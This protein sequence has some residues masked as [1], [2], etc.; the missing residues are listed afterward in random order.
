MHYASSLTWPR[1]MPTS[2]RHYSERIDLKRLCRGSGR[3]SSST[4]RTWISGG[5]LGDLLAGL[6]EP[7]EAIACLERARAL[8]ER[9]VRASIFRSAGL[10]EQDGRMSEAEEH[11]RTALR[12]Q[13][14]WPRSMFTSVDSMRF[15]GSLDDGR[16]RFPQVHRD[17]ARV[18]TRACPAGD[19]AAVDC[20]QTRTRRNAERGWLIRNCAG[21]CAPGSCSAW[22]TCSMRAAITTVRPCACERPMPCRQG[23]PRVIAGARTTQGLVPWPTVSQRSFVTTSSPGRRAPGRDSRRPVFVFGL[24][25]SGTTLIEQILASHSRV[26]GGRRAAPGRR[27]PSKRS[28][29]WRAG[30]EPPW[31]VSPTS[32]PA[33]VA[34]WPNSTSSGC[35]AGRRP[36]RAGRGQDAG[37]LPVSRLLAVLFPQAT[38]IHCRRDL[39]DVAVSC[40]MTDF[41]SIRWANDPEHIARAFREYR[42]LMDHWQAVLPV[43]VHEVDYE[44]TVADLEAVAP[45]ADRGV[46]PGVGAGLP[47]IPPN[48]RPVR[49]ASVT[50]VR[51][52]LYRRSVGRWKNY[53]TALADLFAR[54]PIDEERPRRD[55]IGGSRVE[56]PAMVMA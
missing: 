23:G 48:Q 16:G 34:G 47:G 54:L 41:R 22:L 31:N 46:R 44:E 28:P 37:Q 40:W 26:H 43:A 42:R 55:G 17:H 32:T 24:P 45:A 8:A 15:A 33:G 53:E 11:Y 4:R 25:R 13:P 30:R 39:R 12:L 29:P 6:G 10:K 56:D 18:S 2:G 35:G 3:R 5:A 36:G 38:F 20:Y 27:S 14:D 51:Q 1:P 49:T 50:Q 7:A 21:R 19:P 52:P 9:S